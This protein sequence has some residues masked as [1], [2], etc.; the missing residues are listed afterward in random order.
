MYIGLNIIILYKNIL[1][2]IKINIQ[3]KNI[4]SVIKGKWSDGNKLFGKAIYELTQF[5][6]GISKILFTMK[7]SEL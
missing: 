1:I 3:S 4:S 7:C 2:I 5:S 6:S